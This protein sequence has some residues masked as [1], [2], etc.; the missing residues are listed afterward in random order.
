MYDP[1]AVTAF[2]IK[3]CDD[4]SNPSGRNRLVCTAAVYIDAKYTHIMV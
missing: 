1:Q 3:D 2:P 4:P